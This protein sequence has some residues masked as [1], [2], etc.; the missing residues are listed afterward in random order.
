MES[1][2]RADR[3]IL[4]AIDLSY[5][6]YRAAAAHPMLTSRRVFTGGLYGFFMTFAKMVRETKATHVCF[7]MDTKPYLRSKTYPE[8]KLIR[9]KS[10]DPELQL[11]QKESMSLVLQTLED[12]GLETWAIQGFESDDLIAHCVN[13]YRHRFHMIYAGSNDSDLFQWLHIPNFAIYTK[14]LASVWTSAKLLKEQEL[15]PAEFMLST[16]I[17]GTH[18]DVAGIMG[19]GPKTALK[20]IK[21]PGTMRNLRAIYSSVIDRNLD[22]IKLPHADFPFAATIPMHAD[23]FN[24]RQLYRSL[25][26]YDIDVTPTIV[27]AF[28]QLL[29]R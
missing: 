11:R 1:S 6:T 22:L 4:L 3:K 28:E 15:T 21:D 20:A 16:A 24:P 25:G 7:C 8:Y 29:V 5:Q 14:D 18:N 12:C 26:Q 9:K 2:R 23:K 19:V 10:A 13:K 17:T 27:N